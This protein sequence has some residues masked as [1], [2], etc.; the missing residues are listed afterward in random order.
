MQQPLPTLKTFSSLPSLAAALS[1][2]SSSCEAS[3]AS[4]RRQ[5]VSTASASYSDSS[6][7]DAA[8]RMTKL[9]TLRHGNSAAVRV[10]PGSASAVHSCWTLDSTVAP[11]LLAV[12]APRMLA[13]ALCDSGCQYVLCIQTHPKHSGA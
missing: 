8:V 6:V 9:S 5:C 12:L 3:S 4:C 2:L 10:S 11:K 13:P 1:N 7:T